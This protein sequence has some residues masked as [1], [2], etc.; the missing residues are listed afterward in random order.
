MSQPTQPKPSDLQVSLRHIDTLLNQ[1]LRCLNAVASQLLAVTIAVECI[2]LAQK[3]QRMLLRWK[4]YLPFHEFN[5]VDFEFWLG[6]LSG[7]HQSLNTNDSQRPDV[8]YSIDFTELLDI[9]LREPQGC[10]LS[11]TEYEPASDDQKADPIYHPRY[12]DDELERDVVEYVAR[13]DEQMERIDNLGQDDEQVFYTMMDKEAMRILGQ[14]Y[15]D[16]LRVIY[17]KNNDYTPQQFQEDVLPQAKHYLK[18]I[19]NQPIMAYCLDMAMS[20]LLDALRQI[21]DLFDQEPTDQQLLRLSLRLYHRHCSDADHSAS[22][23]VHRWAATWPA[24]HRQECALN[25]RQQL[26]EELHHRYKEPPLHRY[27]DTENPSPLTDVE[28]GRY[29]YTCRQQ[30]TIR[31]VQQL[32]A[33][34]Y[35]IHH[36]NHFVD[37]LSVEADISATRLN[38]QRKEIYARLKHLVQQGHW[39]N[40]M[41]A[42]R[43]QGCFA[44]L[45]LPASNETDEIHQAS[46]IFWNLLTRRRGCD[47]EFRSLKLTWLNLV[48]Y[49]CSRGVMKGG[50]KSLCNHFFP[51][52]SLEGEHNDNDR[53]QINKGT[54]DRAPYEFQQLRPVLDRLLKIPEQEHPQK[55]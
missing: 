49:F 35:R 25:K 2:T 31:D 9:V 3:L 44:R 24:R 47:Q 55:T 41:T 52:G 1:L 45:L 14:Q 21:K 51:D 38:Q 5:D 43:V 7:I 15:A 4:V 27:V 18:N 48:G 34:C 22:Q 42:E 36:L 54:D 29:L 12:S 17:T 8:P 30:L 37:P 39:L 16:Y 23:E 50:N 11:S 10:D 19:V 46:D 26:I 40:G 53:N 32:F 6:Y 20:T 28:F 13:V 33:S